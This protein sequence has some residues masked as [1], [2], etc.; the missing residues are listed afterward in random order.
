MKNNAD[1]LIVSQTKFLRY[2]SE[3][4]IHM[5]SEILRLC[6]VIVGVLFITLC[7][8]TYIRKNLTEKFTW[9]WLFFGI[10]LILSGIIPVF[11]D[12]ITTFNDSG[13][14]LAAIIA[15]IIVWFMFVVTK[16]IARLRRRNQELAMHVSLLNQEN[17]RI[18]A[19]ISKMTG[20][21]K[22]KI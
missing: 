21:D 11:S 9:M 2:V 13:Y 8:L 17:E 20:E 1:I 22:S 19:R 12:W 10:I 4:R 18:L 7:L 5:N 15:V 3:W 6:V 14:R 16:E